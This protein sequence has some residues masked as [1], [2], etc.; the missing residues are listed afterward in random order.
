MIITYSEAPSF[1]QGWCVSIDTRRMVVLLGLIDPA[2]SF[3][4]TDHFATLDQAYASTDL[5][6]DEEKLVTDLFSKIQIHIDSYEKWTLDGTCHALSIFRGDRK[7]GLEWNSS[8]PPGCIGVEALVE[9]LTSLAEACK[10]K[11]DRPGGRP[12]YNP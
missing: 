1:S 12:G 10:D 8:V 4:L 5:Q 11:R 9:N 6:P 2:V 7:I 3:S